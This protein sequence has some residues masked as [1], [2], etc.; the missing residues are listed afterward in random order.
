MELTVMVNRDMTPADVAAVTNSGR[1]DD[2]W[3]N[4]GCGCCQT[5]F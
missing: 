4:G 3:G 5:A 2:C 1:E